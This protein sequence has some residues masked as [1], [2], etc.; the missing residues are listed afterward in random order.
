[1][2]GFFRL[3][4]RITG[5]MFILLVIVA[6]ITNPNK[7]DFATKVKAELNKTVSEQTNNPSLQYIAEMGSEFTEQVVEKLL[8]RKNFYVCSVF[9]LELPDGD[10][11]YLG[12][13][14]LFYP[15]QDENPLDKLV[16][17]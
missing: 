9:T 7:E 5:L 13:F 17:N 10:Y 12:A 6:L 8:I 3:I 15:L 1:M 16:K 2:I 4:V 14:Q 11:Q